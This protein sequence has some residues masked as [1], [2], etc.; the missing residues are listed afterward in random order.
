MQC[1]K[2][3]PL[4][5]VTTP[6]G[7]DVCPLCKAKAENSDLCDNVDAA[8]QDLEDQLKGTLEGKLRAEL[9]KYHWKKQVPNEAGCWL[10][11]NARGSAEMSMVFKDS[12]LD[13]KLAIFWGW[14]PQS[15][16]LIENIKDKLGCF[17]WYGPITLPEGE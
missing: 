7:D 17:C 8:R 5:V 2:H 16:C 13:N 4:V 3:H 14:S 12:H 15:K 10:R 1:L 6:P 9:D 11:I